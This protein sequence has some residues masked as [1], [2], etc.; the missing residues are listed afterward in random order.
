[1][2]E[3]ISNIFKTIE[4]HDALMYD[5]C[6]FYNQRRGILLDKFDYIPKFKL[7]AIDFGGQVD[8][9][10]YNNHLV[11]P[12]NLMYN[13]NELY[14][15]GINAFIEKDDY[16]I[17]QCATES[18]NLYLKNTTD[19]NRQLIYDNYLTF[20]SIGITNTHSGTCVGL[21]YPA[22][23]NNEQLQIFRN[24]I[25]KEYDFSHN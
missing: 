8:T 7:I 22:Y 24:K 5:T 17:A 15:K 25:E 13:Y 14:Q 10:E 4:P 21:I 2:A 9:I 6:V 23:F 3:E 11:I 19:F 1:M 18:L 12:T 16:K 20:E